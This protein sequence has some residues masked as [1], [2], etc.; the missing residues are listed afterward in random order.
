MSFSFFIHTKH[1]GS[2]PLHSEPISIGCEAWVDLSRFCT[3]EKSWPKP[4]GTHSKSGDYFHASPSQTSF[5]K[6]FADL[7]R[8]F[9]RRFPEDL[10]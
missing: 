9:R 7:R 4:I 8:R 3:A 6:S 10:D 1:K 5:T 2:L